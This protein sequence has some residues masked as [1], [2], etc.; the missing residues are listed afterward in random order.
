MS[1][2]LFSRAQK[3]DTNPNRKFFNLNNK[4]INN[5]LNNNIKYR[6]NIL[7]KDKNNNINYY[8]ENKKNYKINIK[9]KKPGFFK[10]IIQI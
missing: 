8:K 9:I 10:K 2:F 1:F 7:D 6:K 4:V 3:R 5:D